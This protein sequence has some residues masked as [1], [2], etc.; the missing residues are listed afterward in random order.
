MENNKLIIKRILRENLEDNV[1]EGKFARALG[2]A[3]MAATTMLPSNAQAKTTEPTPISN[4]MA[5]GVVKNGN[6]YISTTST[7]G[8]TKE[9]AKELAITKAQNQILEKLGIQNGSLE[10]INIMKEKFAKDNKGNIICYITISARV[11]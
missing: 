10:D 4:T 7:S 5:S 2:T 11:K 8:P 6:G 3:A 1:E 9:F